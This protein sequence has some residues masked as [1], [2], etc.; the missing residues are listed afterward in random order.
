MKWMVLLRAPGQ[1]K[2]VYRYSLKEAKELAI[3]AKKKYKHR[4]DVMVYLISCQKAFA[5]PEGWTRRRIK[6]SYWC[7]Y[8]ATER[9]FYRNNVWGTDQCG[10]CGITTSDFW[11]RTYNHLWNKDSTSKK[12][13]AKR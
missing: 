10:V 6:R 3:K 5:P 8:C 1:D 11:V 4:D 12:K 13:R 7:P 9:K 2:K